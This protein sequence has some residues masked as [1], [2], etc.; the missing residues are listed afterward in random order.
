MTHLDNIRAA[1]EEMRQAVGA[2][3]MAMLMHGYPLD[4]THLEHTCT[5]VAQDEADQWGTPLH[6]ELRN[7]I[8]SLRTIKHNIHTGKEP[9]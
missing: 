9:S 7:V 5:Q 6:V 3:D 4:A 8:A 1:T 2:V